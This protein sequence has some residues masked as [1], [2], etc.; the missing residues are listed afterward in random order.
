MGDM[1]NRPLFSLTASIDPLFL[2]TLQAVFDDNFECPG[3]K[4]EH[5]MTQDWSK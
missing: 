5:S 4:Y 2:S 3:M 1:V